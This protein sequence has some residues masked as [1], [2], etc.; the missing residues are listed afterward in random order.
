MKNDQIDCI[1]EIVTFS[2]LPSADY[3]FGLENY[4]IKLFS[5]SAFE[6]QYL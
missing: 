6:A 2:S 4:S 3:Y 1:I 5:Y